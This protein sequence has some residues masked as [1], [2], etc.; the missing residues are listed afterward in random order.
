M[1]TKNVRESILERDNNSCRKCCMTNNLE[2]HHIISM[3]DGGTDDSSNLISLCG[4]CHEE[5]HALETRSLIPFDMWLRM[6]TLSIFITTFMGHWSDNVTAAQMKETISTV[7]EISKHE[8]L[9]KRSLDERRS[10]FTTQEH[11]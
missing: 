7:H 3:C 9:L 8:H 6:P 1:L 10:R 5:W 2:V 4:A 11:Q